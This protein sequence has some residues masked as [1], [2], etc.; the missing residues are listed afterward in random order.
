M[1]ARHKLQIR[2]PSIVYTFVKITKAMFI[3][4]DL[5]KNSQVTK[6]GPSSRGVLAVI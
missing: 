2:S 1:H 5:E 4:T 3:T 6:C